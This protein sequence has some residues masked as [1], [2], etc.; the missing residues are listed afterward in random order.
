M[1][2]V[3]ALVC[4]GALILASSSAMAQGPGGGRGFGGPGGGRGFGGGFG[5]FGGDLFS[6]LNNESVKKEIELVPS[7]SEDIDELNA[8]MRQ[9][10]QGAFRGMGRGAT[11]EDREEAME[12]LQEVR[13][14]SEKKLARILMPKQLTR[15]KQIQVQQQ[16]RG[17]GGLNLTGGNIAEELGLTES[18]I[19]ELRA[20]AEKQQ[21]ELRA[22]MAQLRQEADNE[23]IK[24]LTP[25][26]Q[27]TWKKMVG[28]PFEMEMERGGFPSGPGGQRGTRGGDRGQRGPRG[29]RGGNN[30]DI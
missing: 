25:E 29:S 8:E 28:E 19:E 12:K 15:V 11:A 17:P 23:L 3:V 2:I 10:M 14:S 30:D 13:E 16:M 22:K 21:E 6:L 4:A 26:Q 18:Q 20:K 9:E 5:G 7:Q 1:K 24:M 27:A